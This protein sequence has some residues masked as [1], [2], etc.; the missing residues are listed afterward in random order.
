VARAPDQ[1]DGKPHSPHD[2]AYPRDVWTVRK[3]PKEPRGSLGRGALAAQPNE[4]LDSQR[5]AFLHHGAVREAHPG[6]LELPESERW[7]S[8]AQRLSCAAD[9]ARFFLH[10]RRSNSGEIYN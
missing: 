3:I 2:A 8:T 6:F 1:R 9:Q 10:R 7:V 5:L 4:R